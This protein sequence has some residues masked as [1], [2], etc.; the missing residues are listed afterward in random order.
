MLTRHGVPL[1]EDDVYSELHF[2]SQPALPVKAYEAQ[3]SGSAVLHCGSFSKCLAPGF[4]VG[5]VA[6]GR[7]APALQRLKLSSSLGGSWPA[8]AA[9]AEYLRSGGFDHHLRGLRQALARQRDTLS[10]AVT[11]HFPAGTR[12]T[13]PQGGY[14]L[15]LEL[16]AG[17]DSLALHGQALREGISLAPGPMFSAR[18]EFGHCLRLNY[19]QPWTPALDAA[20][21]RL[22]EL[23]WLQLPSQTPLPAS[24]RVET[25]ALCDFRQRPHRGSMLNLCSHP[26]FPPLFLRPRSRC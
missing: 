15:W 8:Q 16:P 25:P 2:A 5:W 14:F 18:R 19:G 10:A 11:R 3:Q 24:D 9:L 7:F 6:A 4:R 12:M 23:A 26:F 22:G 20:L 21:A 13:L 17:C 1:I